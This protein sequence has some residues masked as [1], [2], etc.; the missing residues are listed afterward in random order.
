MG[1]TLILYLAAAAEAISVVLLTERGNVQKPIYFVSR[2]LQGSEINYPNLEKVALA[3]VHAA[4]RLRHYFQAYTICV[5][6]DQPIRQVLLKP[7]NSGRIAKWAIELGE[8][9]ILYKPR[10]I[11]KGQILADFL[12]ESPT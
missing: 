8:H 3:L 6:T 4:R 1:E 7:K 12:A 10:S 2:A 11:V 9:E 5:V